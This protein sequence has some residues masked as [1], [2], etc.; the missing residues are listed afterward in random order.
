MRRFENLKRQQLIELEKGNI[1]SKDV[2]EGLSELD[3]SELLSA[4]TV[5]VGLSWPSISLVFLPQE[6]TYKVG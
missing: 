1:Y 5:L 3:R 2:V 6:C 4:N